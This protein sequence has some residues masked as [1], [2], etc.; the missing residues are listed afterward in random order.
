MSGKERA[1][2]MVPRS[3]HSL[4]WEINLAF[5]GSL[6]RFCGGGSKPSPC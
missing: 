5:D 1:Q 2:P 3:K 4:G 6:E